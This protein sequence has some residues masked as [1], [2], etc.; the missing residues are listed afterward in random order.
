MLRYFTMAGAARCMTLVSI[1]AIAMILLCCCISQADTPRLN[2][3]TFVRP[4]SA[5]LAATVGVVQSYTAV[6][7]TFEGKQF[8]IGHLQLRDEV[9]GQLETYLIG[10]SF[11]LDGN[12][13]SCSDTAVIDPKTASGK[14]VLRLP[15]FIDGW[16]AAGKYNWQCKAAPLEFEPLQ[17][18]RIVLVYWT[19]SRETGLPAR[20][21]DEGWRTKQ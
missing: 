14:P 6:A 18:R 19:S 13:M 9:S 8:Y 20:F 15:T 12:P 1:A 4:P 2:S 11:T 7:T 3:P 17:G 10:D 5:E 16:D 21:S